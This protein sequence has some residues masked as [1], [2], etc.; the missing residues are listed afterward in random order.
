[1]LRALG[2]ESSSGRL[3]ALAVLD[4]GEAL[5]TVSLKPPLGWWSAKERRW[6]GQLGDAAGSAHPLHSRRDLSGY[7]GPEVNA[8][9]LIYTL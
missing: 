7:Y 8:A 3:V 6:S 9:V 1:M 2:A 5:L 4:P